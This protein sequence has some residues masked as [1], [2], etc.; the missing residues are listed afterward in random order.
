MHR[1]IV[2]L[3]GTVCMAAGA[4]LWTWDADE[5]MSRAQ[6]SCHVLDVAVTP[7]AGSFRVAMSL[8][9]D[10]EVHEV[11]EWHSD[12]QRAEAIYGA[13]PLESAVPCFLSADGE[14]A[15]SRRAPQPRKWPFALGAALWLAPLVWRWRRGRGAGEVR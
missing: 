4:V 11:E 7:E 9:H 12:R 8:V 3:A 13:Y 10:G 15:R 2:W 5:A 14:I 6:T 1:W